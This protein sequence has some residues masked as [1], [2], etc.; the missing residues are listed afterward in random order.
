MSPKVKKKNFVLTCF[1][2]KFFFAILNFFIGQA[3]FILMQGEIFME[4]KFNLPA[5][6]KQIGNINPD[7]KL[8]IYIEDYAYNYLKQYAKIDG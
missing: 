8:K 1:D 5:N 6:L 2:K 4:K 7:M 3:F